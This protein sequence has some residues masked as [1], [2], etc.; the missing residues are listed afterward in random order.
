M[1]TSTEGP[2]S[3]QHSE[4]GKTQPAGIT[5]RFQSTRFVH[6]GDP[7]GFQRGETGL[8]IQELEQHQVLI[9]N[10]GHHMESC[11]QNSEG[12]ASSIEFWTQ[13]TRHER[14]IKPGGGGQIGH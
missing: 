11:L 2:T 9:S 14:G 13:P 1:S 7:E 4:Q 12:K 10:T 8:Y 3:R 6:S 5:A